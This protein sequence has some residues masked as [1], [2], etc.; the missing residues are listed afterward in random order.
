MA[1]SRMLC[2]PHAPPEISTQLLFLGGGQKLNPFWGSGTMKN[3]IGDP[4]KSSQLSSRRASQYDHNDMIMF[5]HYN[6][7]HITWSSTCDH[8]HMNNMIRTII[9]KS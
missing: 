7:I 4:S 2:V 3:E 9:M 8:N 6:M 1:V 5:N